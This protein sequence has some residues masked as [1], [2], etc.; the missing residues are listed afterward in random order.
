MQAAFYLTVGQYG[1]SLKVYAQPTPGEHAG[2]Q[3]KR[4]W[5]YIKRGQ[6]GG[7]TAKLQYAA[8]EGLGIIGTE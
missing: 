5:A 1:E 2:S 4:A 7:P 8:D 6:G 3:G